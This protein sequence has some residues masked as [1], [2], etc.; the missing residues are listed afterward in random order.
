MFYLSNVIWGILI[1]AKKA[2]KIYK[3][4]GIFGPFYDDFLIKFEKK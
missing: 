2:G 4:L 3:L 1:D